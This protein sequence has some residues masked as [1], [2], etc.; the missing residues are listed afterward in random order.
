MCLRLA[1]AEQHRPSLPLL[2]DDILV[3]F[4]P[5]RAEAATAVL[6]EVAK[7]RQVLV[8]T[9]H[10]WVVDIVQSVQADSGVIELARIA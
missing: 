9:C 2:L 10:P 6:A 5:A 8:F 1:L 7:T 4:D 3:N